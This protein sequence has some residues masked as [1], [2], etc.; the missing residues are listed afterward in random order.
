MSETEKPAVVEIKDADKPIKS[1][2]SRK[3]IIGVFVFIVIV[4]S[5]Y[6]IYDQFQSNQGIP[7][8]VEGFIEK[9][10]KTGPEADLSFDMEKEVKRLSDIQEDYLVKLNKRPGRCS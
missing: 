6:F 8:P 7:D 9:T 3:K 10:V 5:A 2:W 1:W 4:V